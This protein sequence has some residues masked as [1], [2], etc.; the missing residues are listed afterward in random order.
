MSGPV[1]DPGA[2]PQPQPA[3][4]SRGWGGGGGVKGKIR[5]K[6]KCV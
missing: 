4:L 2:T 6:R 1:A 5:N 3:P